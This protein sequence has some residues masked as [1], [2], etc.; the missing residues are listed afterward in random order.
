MDTY[1]Y[2]NNYNVFGNY[3]GPASILSTDGKNVRI[4]RLDTAF[5]I[6]LYLFYSKDLMITQLRNFIND[7]VFKGD[8]EIKMHAGGQIFKSVRD[9]VVPEGELTGL[10]MTALDYMR[11]YGMCPIKIVEEARYAR[12][13]KRVVIP[14]I[15][16]GAFYQIENRE[17][18]RSEVVYI[19]DYA[20]QLASASASTFTKEGKGAEITLWDII[21]KYGLAVYVWPGLEP[22]FAT[23]QYNSPVAMLYGEYLRKEEYFKDARECNYDSTH[24]TVF[25]S[26]R[27]EK[28]NP[29]QFTE[30]Q[31]ALEAGMTFLPIPPSPQE[32]VYIEHDTFRQ[33]RMSGMRNISMS[34]NVQH[35][36][37]TLS[38]DTRYVDEMRL[39]HH[40]DGNTIS[41]P[42]N[43]QIVSAPT[44][45]IQVDIFAVLDMY[46]KAV[47]SVMGVPESLIQGQMQRQTMNANEM[48]K[49]SLRTLVET[50]RKQVDLFFRF[51]YSQMYG[52]R[53]YWEI[54][55]ELRLLDLR[56]FAL[57]S[58][59][60][61]WAISNDVKRDSI[62]KA[63]GRDENDETDSDNLSLMKRDTEIEKMREKIDIE[64]RKEMLG[65]LMSKRDLVHLEFTEQPLLGLESPD[66]I[67]KLVQSHLA[68]PEEGIQ[69]VRKI[70]GMPEATPAVMKELRKGFE[71]DRMANLIKMTSG[72]GGQGSG[73]GSSGG[74]SKLHPLSFASDVTKKRKVE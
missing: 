51:V 39:R 61:P 6:K 20:F 2:A 32:N 13:R 34:Q 8:I 27:M 63:R 48:V 15:G 4:Q 52:T 30:R 25:T 46:H 9:A 55:S 69:I 38:Q 73:G 53:D 3:G 35:T 18:M 14:Q 64:A 17:L 28:T 5:A 33:K 21:I 66:T 29:A 11:L 36:Q 16:M 26:A 45:K 49:Q 70:I 47:S 60:N 7:L 44:P 57:N 54:V 22:N 62:A 23:N 68:T 50:H 43:E 42:T 37:Y 59:H 71:E 65:T 12:A 1:N 19:P 10:L 40:W 24:P 67:I 72:R 56:T 58:G 41:L 74:Q 31:L